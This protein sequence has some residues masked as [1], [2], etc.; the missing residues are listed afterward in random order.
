[1]A[2]LG[3]A[4]VFVLAACTSGHRSGGGPSS[5]ARASASTSAPPGGA[6][7]V[8]VGVWEQPDVA[9]PTVGG[10]A[11][12]ALVL[13]QL[14]VVQPDGSWAPS[15]V[16]PGSVHD[17][18]GFRSA[19][20]R[21]RRGAVWSNGAPITAA[22]LKRSADQRFVAGID[23]PARDGTVT[24]RFTQ[25][26][27]GWRRLWSGL[28]A[29]SAPA[30]G[31][32][33]GP[34]VLAG[35]TPG[36]DVVL[37]RN[38]RWY[39]RPLA[40]IA[41]LRLV[42]V[43]DAVT[44]RQLLQRGALDVVMPPAGT[45]RTPQLRGLPGVSVDVAAPGGWWVGLLLNPAR[46]STDARRALVATVDRAPFVA[47]LL[48]DEAV[49]ATG[50]TGPRDRTWAAVGAGDA[51]KLRN[52]TVDLV[53]ENE[54]PLIVPL[55]R[56]MQKRARPAGG[57]L[58]LRDAEAD[59]VDSWVAERAY[60][61][62]VVELLDPPGEC[63]TCRWGF[64]DAGLARAADAGDRS[65]IVALESRLRDDAFVLP[66]WRPLTVVA[67]RNGITGVKAN[68]YAASAAWN[69]WEWQRHG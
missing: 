43:P 61:A 49:L 62:A 38:P 57:T 52:K 32:W 64:V 58:S 56:S 44:A 35:S 4:V 24:V 33:G 15:L 42:L 41:E 12:R 28:D 25:P 14:F 30:P 46:L 17:G 65:A 55:E 27:P 54:E 23:G 29:V 1:M 37:R 16:Q 5:T 22:D 67:W 66:L 3:L 59:R 39:G 50:F 34:F 51:S 10:G 53:A 47:V 2:A 11:V 68:P 69:A 21:L 18:A 13:P 19:S 20:F 6:A 60:D 36:L 31:V 26:L 9:A 8:R 7:A 48:R 45:N 40:S 63:W